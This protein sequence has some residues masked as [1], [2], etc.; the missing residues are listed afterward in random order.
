MR[1]FDIRLLGDDGRE[2]VFLHHLTI[3]RASGGE[4]APPDKLR[5]LLHRLRT[6]EISEAEAE[7]AMEASL[8]N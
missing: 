3:K 2:L 5:A 8:A 4:P 1:A 6:G 7:T